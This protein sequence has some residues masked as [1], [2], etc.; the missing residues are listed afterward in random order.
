MDENEL[1]SDVDIRILSQM[2]N[3]NLI[4]VCFKSK[5]NNMTIQNGSYV[6]NIDKDDIGGSHWICL[7]VNGKNAVYFDSFGEECPTEILN[8][9]KGKKLIMNSF[10]LQDIIDIDCGWWCI[11]FL[12]WMT[13][14]K[15][16]NSYNLNMFN[17]QFNFKKPKENRKILQNY[18]KSITNQNIM[19]SGLDKKLIEI[20]NVPKSNEIWKYSNPTEVRNRA[21]NYLNKNIPIYLSD[22][23]EKKYM[24]K[25]ANNK[26][27]HF[28]Q[29]NFS[30]FTQHKNLIRREN[31]LNRSAKI[32]GN[33]KNDKYSANNLSRNLLW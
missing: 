5:F 27:V 7:Y 2:F 33:W 16:A 13:T 11:G 9:C 26:W 10:Q 17:K 31:Y 28:G 1:L 29:L 23:P 6:I 32:K 30:D 14:Y 3:I 21:N 8:F 12:H 25:N 19:G 15:I 24:V 22:K 20:S 18:I 4:D